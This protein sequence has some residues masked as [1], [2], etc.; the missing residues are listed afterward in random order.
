MV[1]GKKEKHENDWAN[2]TY[3]FLV[4]GIIIG[5]I[6]IVAFVINIKGSSNSVA[7]Q[8]TDV[9]VP[10]E[11]QEEYMK[12]EYYMESVPYT[13]QECETKNL[14]YSIE[15]TNYDYS[16]CNRQEEKCID[17][18]LGIC[19]SKKVYCVDRTVSCSLDLKNL[20]A[21]QG[22]QWT[23]L[24]NFYQDGNIA[25]TASTSIYLYPQT[26]K[27]VVNQVR[28]TGTDENGEANV[29]TLNGG[30]NYQTT[31]IPTKQVCKD[32]IK[33]QDVQRERQVTAFRPITKYKTEQQC[34]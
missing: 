32:I 19:T 18:F 31:Y 29:L 15:N 8:C 16:T 2:T 23:I 6:A 28:L 27:S 30:C 33:Y 13:D 34:N 9:Q 5:I 17:Y 14:A 10:Y 22:G 4:V 1:K 24:H 26:I 11:D 3:V 12:T 21:E 20:D 25:K 7:N